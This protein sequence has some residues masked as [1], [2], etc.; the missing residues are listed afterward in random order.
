MNVF[1]TWL[2]DLNEAMHLY[3]AIVKLGNEN[4]Q[5]YIRPRQVFKFDSSDQF[6]LHTQN[7]SKLSSKTQSRNLNSHSS[8]NKQKMKVFTTAQVAAVLAFK[9]CASPVPEKKTDGIVYDAP[10]GG[11]KDIDY[12]A[13][14]GENLPYYPPPPE[15][16]ESVKYPPGTGSK[17]SDDVGEVIP[18]IFSR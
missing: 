12:P 11:Y 3:F 13:G 8:L 6:S 7:I 5:V 18:S 2:I 16:W 17:D 9:A 4:L 1:M 10:S 15:G 14:T